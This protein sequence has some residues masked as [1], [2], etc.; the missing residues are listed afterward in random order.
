MDTGDIR[1]RY[2]KNQNYGNLK[3][4]S[5]SDSK[6]T[7]Q[8]LIDKWSDYNILLNYSRAPEFNLYIFF[9]HTA[10][11]KMDITNETVDFIAELCADTSKVNPDPIAAIVN[12]FS[13]AADIDLINR[14]S[15]NNHPASAFLRQCHIL[16]P[17]C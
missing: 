3:I 1:G 6:I 11:T 4:Q 7:Q 10:L 12:Y 17:G 13:M 15:R 14:I 16:W 5:E 2:G 8:E 9:D